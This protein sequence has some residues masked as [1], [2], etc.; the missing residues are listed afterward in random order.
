MDPYQI[1]HK[2]TTGTLG[3]CV[4]VHMIKIGQVLL[5]L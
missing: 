4:K 1:W 2:P 3:P 5:E